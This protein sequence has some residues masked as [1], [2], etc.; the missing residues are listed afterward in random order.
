MK[1]AIYG[2]KLQSGSLQVINDFFKLITERDI[3]YF[4]YE[5][6]FKQ[7]KN[8]VDFKIQPELFN[9][10]D[11]LIKNEVECLISLGGDGTFL[12]TLTI[13]RN[14]NLPVLGF[15]LGRLGFLSSISIDNIDSA[16]TTLMNRHYV[17]EKRSLLQ[18]ES[19]QSLFNNNSFA[20]NDFTIHKR[21][22]AAMITIHTYLNGELLNTYWA[23]GLV[24]STPTGSTAYSLSCGGPVIFPDAKSFVVT[25]VASHNISI[26]PI[27]I[28]DDTILSFEIEGRGKNFLVS[29]DSRYEIV[30]YG[31]QLAV[32]KSKFYMNLIKLNTQNFI[33]TLREKLMLGIDNRNL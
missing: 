10:V 9:Q 27:I 4:I 1:I 17:I 18:M 19:T 15:N 3:E 2:R 16:F 21:D 26:R 8:S 30:D 7:I 29:L 25:P 23:D 11:K 5:P 20:L 22:T 13:V 24:V 33:S 31:C 28:P 14:S 6:Y 32:S 12:D